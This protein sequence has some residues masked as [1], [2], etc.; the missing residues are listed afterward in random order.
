M[1]QDTKFEKAVRIAWDFLYRSG[2]IDEPAVAYQFVNDTI[3]GKMAMGESNVLRLANRTI[4]EYHDFRRERR[5]ILMDEARR[6]RFA[7]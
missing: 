1:E 2:A 5:R 7:S 3:L 6:A 4:S